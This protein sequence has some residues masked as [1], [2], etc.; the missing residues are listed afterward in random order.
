VRT[1]RFTTLR[2]SRILRRVAIQCAH[3]RQRAAA[4]PAPWRPAATRRRS[5]PTLLLPRPTLSP[6]LERNRCNRLATFRA[7]R[8]RN[9]TVARFE[10]AV[11]K[12][13]E[14]RT[15]DASSANR[16]SYYASSPRTRQ[17]HR[18]TRPDTRRTAARVRSSGGRTA[19]GR[20]ERRAP[21]CATYLAKIGQRRRTNVIES[22]ELQ[23]AVAHFRR[24][25]TA[26]R[27]R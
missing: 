15:T 9:A 23:S 1:S 16:T 20:C 22:P 5:L 27:V 24:P 17:L 13:P 7:I 21:Q 19:L 18:T 10:A 26:S 3:I 4:Q 6:K 12:V 11:I 25:A 2:T 14:L 8:D